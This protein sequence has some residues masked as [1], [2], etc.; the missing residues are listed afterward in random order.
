MEIISRKEAKNNGL[1]FYFTG[2]PC[3]R[4]HVCNRL[5]SCA[6]CT[7]CGKLRKRIKSPND[8]IWREKNREKLKAQGRARYAKNP[9]KYVNKTKAY[10][11]KNG[12]SVRQKR[13]V[14]HY[15]VYK[16]PSVRKRASERTREWALANNEKYRANLRNTKAKRKNV[17]GKHTADDISEILKLQRSKCAYCNVRLGKKYHVDHILAVSRGGTNDRK[18]LQITC[19]TCNLSKW[20][21]DPIVFAQRHGKLL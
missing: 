4:G 9:E 21:T 8:L 3:F 5:V 11:D 19:I 15:E 1:I 17:K 14:Y 10:Y 2:K 16:D 13:R 12:E 20:A 18:N 7:G 6:Q